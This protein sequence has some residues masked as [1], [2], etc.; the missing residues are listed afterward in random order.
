MVGPDQVLRHLGVDEADEGVS[1]EGRPRVVDLGDGAEL[2]E[3]A[4]EVVVRDDLGQPGH[5][6]LAVLGPAAGVVLR[7]GDLHV[8]PAVVDLMQLLQGLPFRTIKNFKI[9]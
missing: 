7:L 5:E 2:G 9:F 1:P 6:D 3:V 8:A 4:L